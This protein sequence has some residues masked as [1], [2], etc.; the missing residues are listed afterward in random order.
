[1]SGIKDF[2]KKAFSGATGGILSGASE[3][4]GKFVADPTEKAKAIAELE[5]M[6]IQHEQRLAELDVELTTKLEAEISDR[7]KA[8]MASDSWLSKNVRP[9]SLIS[10][11]GFLFVIIITDSC[12]IPFE[13][14]GGYI[15]LMEAL[16][17]T[18]VVAY[19]GGRSAEKVIRK[20]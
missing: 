16:L 4:I 2:I 19:F 10:L 5:K 9:L 14:K 11:L 3:I 15:D 12:D 6:K 17:L 1:M 7:W 20:K 18:V 13:V 8:D